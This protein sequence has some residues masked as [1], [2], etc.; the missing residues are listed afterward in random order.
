MGHRVPRRGEARQFSWKLQDGRVSARFLIQD[1]DAKFPVAFDQVFEAEDVTII[2]TPF[3][4][5]KANAVAERW[6][7]AVREECLDRVLILGERHL[8]HMLKEYVTYFNHARPERN[9]ES[10]ADRFAVGT[11]SE[12]SFMIITA[13]LHRAFG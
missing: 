6:I 8:D 4:S 5:P 1:R 10:R 13:K 12:E 11:C 2:R 9:G 3:R 7:R